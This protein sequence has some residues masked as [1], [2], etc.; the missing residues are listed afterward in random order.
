M[1]ITPATL[2]MG[3][4]QGLAGLAGGNELVEGKEGKEKRR[5][6]EKSYRHCVLFRK[7]FCVYFLKTRTIVSS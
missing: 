7:Y 2:G 6:A 5:L 1:S 3:G 4:G